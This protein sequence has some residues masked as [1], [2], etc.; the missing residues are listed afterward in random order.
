MPTLRTDRLASVALLVTA[1]VFAPR[2]AILA[3]SVVPS[4]VLSAAALLVGSAAAARIAA[5]RPNAARESDEA[6]RQQN[7]CDAMG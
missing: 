6:E 7:D 4:A 3:A 1:I 2:V 5:F